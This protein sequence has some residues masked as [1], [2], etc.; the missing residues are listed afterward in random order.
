M[1]LHQTFY[2]EEDKN[3]LL[4]REK[5]LAPYTPP[6]PPPPPYGERNTGWLPT[7]PEDFGDGGAYPEVDTPQYPLEMG[8]VRMKA[9][10]DTTLALPV[11]S[12]GEKR[13]E[14]IARVGHGPDRRIQ[15]QLSDTL[16]KEFDPEALE[17]PSAAQVA[18]ETAEAQ[19]ALQDLVAQATA[20][21][22]PKNVPRPAKPSQIISFT[23]QGTDSTRIIKLATMPVDPLQPPKFH[24]KRIPRPPPS[25][26]APRLHSPPRRV[27]S[28]EQKAWHVPPCISSW[29]NPKGYTVPLDKRLASDGRGLAEN[30]INPRLADLAE[31]LHLAEQHNRAEVEMRAVVE[32]KVAE[33][34]RRQRDE[35]LRALAEKARLDARR[36]ADELAYATRQEEIQLSNNSFDNPNGLGLTIRD[37]E[38]LREEQA[39]KRERELRLSRMSAAQREAFLRSDADRDISEIV[40]LGRVNPSSL[41]AQETLYDERLFNQSE[42]VGAGFGGGDDEAYSLYDKPLFAAST[43][44]H[45]IYRPMVTSGEVENEAVGKDQEGGGT[46]SRTIRPDKAFSGSENIALREGPVQFERASLPREDPF[47]LD[48]FLAEAK[49]GKRPGGI[50][51]ENNTKPPSTTGSNHHNHNDNNSSHTGNNP[52]HRKHQ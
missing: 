15:T 21:T 7:K 27:T 10:V 35:Q 9:L 3:V 23:P 44:A 49:K 26:P 40:A 22:Q 20:K 2:P 28:E 19:A 25:P 48:S 4:E 36:L 5:K 18:Q 30:T 47:G 41:A 50:N 32:R 8:R 13:Y 14:I 51:V 52:K 38:R 6:P 33:Q 37:R 16:P 31:A 29:K 45:L 43:A 24:H 17:R 46:H 42:G 39:Q 34:E 11:G 12:S 1:T